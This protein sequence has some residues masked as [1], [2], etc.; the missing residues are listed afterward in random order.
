MNILSNLMAPI[1][2]L[3]ML[4]CAAGTWSVLCRLRLMSPKETKHLVAAQHGVLA[5]GLFS[6]GIWSVNWSFARGLFGAYG[7]VIDLLEQRDIGTLVLVTC[8]FMNL[9]MSSHRWRFRAPSG[10]RRVQWE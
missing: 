10:T 9:M 7:W 2:W 8:V 4:V 6:A 3:T 5:I 1:D